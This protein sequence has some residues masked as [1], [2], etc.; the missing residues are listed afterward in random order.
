MPGLRSI[1]LAIFLRNL[2]AKSLS[3]SAFQS[4]SV[5]NRCVFNN[6]AR[7]L[8]TRL[9]CQVS[10]KWQELVHLPALWKYHCIRLT[11]TDPIPLKAPPSPAEWYAPMQGPGPVFTSL[12]T[13]N[14]F[15]APCTIVNPTSVT[16][17]PKVFD[18]S[19]VTPTFVQRFFYAVRS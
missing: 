13:G 3:I 12:D 4:L 2:P 17:C 10:K 14:H 5:S 6:F 11:A 19:M 9:P 18:S 7:Y 1:L 15:I 8:D 16:G